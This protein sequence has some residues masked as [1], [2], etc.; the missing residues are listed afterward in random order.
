MESI[1][2]TEDLRELLEAPED[3]ALVVEEG[4]ARVVDEAA[5]ADAL[6][7][8]SHENLTTMLDGPGA[9]AT[10]ETLEQLAS[11][12]DNAVREQGV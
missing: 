4:Q 7:I 10:D 3:A 5:A 12:L 6:P 11:G 1:V 2:T 9:D 8:L